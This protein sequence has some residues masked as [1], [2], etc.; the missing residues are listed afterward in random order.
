M[1]YIR[2]FNTVAEYNAAKTLGLDKPNVSYVV[3]SDA[4]YYLGDN[5]IDIV[6][7]NAKAILVDNYDLDG[8]GEISKQEALAVTD[9][10]NFKALFG[11]HSP[12]KTTFT[13]LTFFKYF[14]NAIWPSDSGYTFRDCSN[15]TA[16]DV[17]DNDFSHV[18]KL[19]NFLRGD[20]KL[21]TVNM[22]DLDLSNV[23]TFESFL[24]HSNLNQRLT[25]D[26]SNTLFPE[27]AT[28]TT[29]IYAIKY[30]TFIMNGCTSAAVE[31]IK[32]FIHNHNYVASMK[33]IVDGKQWTC[34]SKG[35]T[36]VESDVAG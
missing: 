25:I 22:R 18:T 36:W 20:T 16:I 35:G 33:I 11:Y 34:S 17:S 31:L 24:N 8:D 29:F 5:I 2:K 1:K 21:S 13:D 7:A 27:S 32:S 28:S 15:V 4:V 6:D 10:S 9:A 23:T 19:S 12:N 26:F 3:E 30:I 14:K